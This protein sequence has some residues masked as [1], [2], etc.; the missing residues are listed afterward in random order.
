MDSADHKM[1]AAEWQYFNHQKKLDKVI[2][3]NRYYCYCGHSVTILPKESRVFCTYCGHW[4]YKDE[5]KQK[6]N[7]KRIKKENQEKIAR[8]KRERFKNQLKEIIK[9]CYI[10]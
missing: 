3:K 5:S 9:K 8:I 6:E 7:I 2:E 10:N 4:I 1:T